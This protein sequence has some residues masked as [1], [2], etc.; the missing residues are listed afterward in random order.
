MSVTQNKPKFIDF[1]ALKQEIKIED[2]V[3]LLGL[4]VSQFNEQMRGPC[5]ACKSGGDRALV[6]TAAKSVYY[7]FAA[8]EGGDV[9]ALT[10]HIKVIGM[11]EAAAFLAE[12]LSKSTETPQQTP[13]ATVPRRKRKRDSTRSHIFNQNIHQFRLWASAQRQHLPLAQ[14]MHQRASCGAGLPSPS[15]MHQE[16]WWPIADRRRRVK[17]RRL[18]SLMASSLRS[19]SSMPIKCTKARSFYCVSHSKFSKRLKVEL[20]TLWRS[21]PKPLHP[22]N[23]KCLPVSWIKEDAKQL[24]YFRPL[25]PTTSIQSLQFR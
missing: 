8:G 22:N 13:V 11:K 1:Q 4:K 3:P 23:S 25:I 21:S 14:D 10:S 15:M 12:T 5:P 7:C 24:K 18:F 16:F 20:K 6:I 9:I 19:L 17:V 2:A